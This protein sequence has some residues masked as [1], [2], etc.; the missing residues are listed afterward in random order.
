MTIGVIGS[1]ICS[2]S[3]SPELLIIGRLVQGIGMGVGATLGRAIMRDLFS[4][5]D[6]AKFGSVLAIGT[7]LMVG[8]A[9]LI[10]GYFQHYLGW[11]SVFGFLAIYSAI[12]WFLVCFLCIYIVLFHSLLC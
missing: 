6:L 8:S 2:I 9:P 3:N 4:G 5:S 1:I 7:T 10:G 11:R 12:I